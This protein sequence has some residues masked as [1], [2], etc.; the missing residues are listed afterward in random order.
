LRAFGPILDPL[1]GA[2]GLNRP[3]VETPF[4]SVSTIR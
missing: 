1:A 4:V 2:S 3:Y